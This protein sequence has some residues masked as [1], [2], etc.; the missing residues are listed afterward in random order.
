MSEQ[1][2]NSS[3]QSLD[4]GVR[5]KIEAGIEASLPA[6]GGQF[7]DPILQLTTPVEH[8][9]PWADGQMADT[10]APLWV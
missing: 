8:V 5:A 9:R 1:V 6:V 2:T 10:V 7:R 4:E 3:A